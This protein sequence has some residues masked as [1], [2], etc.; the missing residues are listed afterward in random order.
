MSVGDSAEEFILIHALPRERLLVFS[1][2]LPSKP[3]KNHF[4][5]HWETI[6]TFCP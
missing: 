5:A 3:V 6:E 4:F 2:G 1:C